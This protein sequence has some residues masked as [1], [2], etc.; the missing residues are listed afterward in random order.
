MKVPPT[1]PAMPIGPM[2]LTPGPPQTGEGWIQE[3]K[4]DGAR[5]ISLVA[6]GEVAIQSRPGN[7]FNR[8]FPE[9]VA[10]LAD[11]LGG[12]TAI[13]DGELVALDADGMPSFSLLQRRLVTT[14]PSTVLKRSVPARLWLFD[15]LHLDGQDLTGLPYR[16]RRSILEELLPGRAGTVAVPPTWADID[17]PTLLEIVADL[18]AEGTVSKRADSIYQ[19]GRRSRAWLKHPIRQRISLGIA[20][21]FPG[22]SMP[23]GALLL[24]GH[25]PQT[26][27]LRYVGSVSS[28]LGPRVS[29]ALADTFRD[30]RAT[31]PPWSDRPRNDVESS[32][33]WLRPGCVAAVEYRDFTARGRFRHLAF[34]GLDHSPDSTPEWLPLP[35]GLA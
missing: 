14:K 2:L 8:R 12:H 5:A 21:Y 4:I 22:R 33:V 11:R 31:S 27:A 29:R 15:C 9:I 28:G 13:L 25:D 18:G 20:G 19:P 6:G 1:T 26:G 34:K 17:G 23:V 24:V 30:F 16:I 7:S 3:L 35:R 10:G 32:V